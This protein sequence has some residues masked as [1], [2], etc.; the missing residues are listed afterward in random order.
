MKKTL[1]IAAALI[2]SASAFAQ[3]VS[4][5]N[6]VGYS[7]V[8]LVPGY[9]VIHVPFID[10]ANPLDIQDVMN[11]SNL[12]QAA[13]SLSSDKIL[14]WDNV[15]L[16]YDVYWLSNGVDGKDVDPL[17]EGKWIDKATDLVASNSVAPSTG[18]FFQR[19]GSTSVTNLF[20]GDVVI[21]ETGTNSITLLEGFSVVA[22][23]FSSEFGLNSSITNW[24]TQGS[25]AAASSLSSDKILFWDNVGLKYDT[26][27]LSN[28]VDGKDVDPLKEGKWID[29]ATDLVASNTIPLNTGFFY[30]RVSAPTLTIE[31]DQ[32]YTL[33]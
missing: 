10:G 25:I 5:A 12:T 16:K 1:V 30:Q 33:D 15:G 29:K 18:F 13:S 21:A 9:S 32:P 26:Y 4:S 3:T 7:Q 11:T 24:V 28:G 14:F 17:K 22:N 23:P 27:W 20:S 6:V 8:E 31:I 19:A 2:V